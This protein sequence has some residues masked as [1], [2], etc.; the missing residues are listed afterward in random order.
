MIKNKILDLIEGSFDTSEKKRREVDEYKKKRS[1]LIKIMIKTSKLSKFR[2]FWIN[3]F[4][5][6]FGCGKIKTAPGTLAS[7][8]TVGI[9]FLITL[10]FAKNSISP[11]IEG[12]IWTTVILVFSLYSI[13]FTPIYTRN[14]DRYDHPSIVIDEVI[15]QLI[16]LTLSYSVVR[17]FYHQESW[18]LPKIVMLAHM[19][20]SFLLFR[21]LDIAKP[22]LIGVIDRNIKNP[23]GVILDDI[24][25]GFAS[26][27]FIIFLFKFYE[28]SIMQLHVF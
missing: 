26:A 6:L 21:T 18:L 9:W 24:V 3:Q 14:F 8:I 23:F 22:S 28:S 15:G 5:T 10:S 7:F 20:L 13:I 12:A 11:L 4:M 25:A 27:I 19:F 2:L 1:R 17:E 16:A